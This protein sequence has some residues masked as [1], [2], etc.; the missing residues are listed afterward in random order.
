MQIPERKQ[1]E[2]EKGKRRDFSRRDERPQSIDL[3]SLSKLRKLFLDTLEWNYR[4][5]KDREHL[6]N[7]KKK[8]KLAS[9]EATEAPKDKNEHVSMLKQSFT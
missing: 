6:Q 1:K 8:G 9:K 5:I 7:Q 4:K 2:Q 3:K